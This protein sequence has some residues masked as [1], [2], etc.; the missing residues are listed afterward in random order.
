MTDM[1]A[2]GQKRSS[3]F[4]LAVHNFTARAALIDH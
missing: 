1:F 4:L 3:K 2:D